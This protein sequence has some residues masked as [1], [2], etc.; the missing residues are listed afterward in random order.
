[1]VCYCRPWFAWT[2][3]LKSVTK[4]I[5]ARAERVSTF[6]RVGYGDS[7]SQRKASSGVGTYIHRYLVT[8]STLR[9]SG[10]RQSWILK[11][12]RYILVVFNRYFSS[13]FN[14]HVYE[15]GHN[16][17]YSIYSRVEL[18]REALTRALPH[19][20]HHHCIEDIETAIES[21]ACKYLS[22][23]SPEEE[24][25]AD[26]RGS[27]SNRKLLTRITT[28]LSREESAGGH[29]GG[30]LYGLHGEEECLY[31]TLYQPLHFSFRPGHQWSTLRKAFVCWGC[32]GGRTL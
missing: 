25:E 21:A 11:S 32:V 14:V 1:M 22:M 8:S 28:Y 31:M 23:A 18:L 12:Y 20:H 24:D 13:T 29:G 17:V 6:S 5:R 15:C 3:W 2:I 16:V 19:P 27:L 4:V 26:R 10:E 30:S 7:Q 9:G